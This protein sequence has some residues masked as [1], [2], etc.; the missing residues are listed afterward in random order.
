MA[1]L[2]ALLVAL[3]Y[4]VYGAD[5]TAVPDGFTLFCFLGADMLY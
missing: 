1:L 2:M 3:L 5:V 4:G